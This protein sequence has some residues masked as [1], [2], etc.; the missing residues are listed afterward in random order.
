[1]NRLCLASLLEYNRSYGLSS[2]E[3]GNCLGGF[4][5]KVLAVTGSPRKGGN[6]DTL[7][8]E[9]LRGAQSA[10]AEVEQVNLARLK[11]K[12]CVACDTCKRTGHCKQ[13][14][15]MQPLY[16]KLLKADA[17]VVGTPVYFWGPSAQMK[18][19]LDRWYA[20]DQAGLREKLAGKRVLLVCP[21]GDTD[22]ETAQP[23]VTMLRTGSTYMGMDW[24]EPLLAPGL[25]G[26][27]EA[28]QDAALLQ[29][30]YAAGV[31]LASQVI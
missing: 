17:L 5:M 13:H 21:F 25:N 11:I 2:W 31:A 24:R 18:A 29:R 8:A 15:D 4:A 16:D 27:D 9:L 1:V 22:P 10:G 7:V 3:K 6:T 28:A 30:A 26:K 23:T 19:F 20:L 12:G 14:D